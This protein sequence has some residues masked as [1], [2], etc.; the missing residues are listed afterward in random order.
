MANSKLI[1]LLALS[2]LAA[3]SNSLAG[4]YKCLDQKQKVVYQDKPCQDLT[5]VKLS[6]ALA[7]LGSG[8]NTPHFIWKVKGEKGAV[9]LLGSLSFGSKDIYP[10]P[11]AIMDAF[12][13]ANVLAIISDVQNRGSSEIPSALIAKGSYADG[14]DLEDH[15]RETTFDKV[16]ELAKKF[17]VPEETITSQQPWLASL[18]LREHALKQSGYTAEYDIGKTFVEAAGTQKPIIKM[19]FTEE[20][21]KLYENAT[22][23]EQ[24]QILLAALNEIGNKGGRLK[25][26]VDAWKKG[27][28]EGMKYIVGQDDENLPAARKLLESFSARRIDALVKKFE[29]WMADGRT[30]FIILDANYLVGEDSLLERM[31]SEGLQVSQL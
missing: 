9:Y 21:L 24:E 29:E 22:E 10:L 31:E 12:A 28:A 26:L 11:E 5:S 15:V 8:D 30:Y 20:Q 3:T 14:S 27:D 6:P 18:T 4:V 17:E 2:L 25:S 16:L 13:T 19:D 1:R 7:Q 23:I